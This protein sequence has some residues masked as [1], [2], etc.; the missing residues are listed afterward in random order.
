MNT[1]IGNALGFVRLARQAGL[2][3]AAA[4]VPKLPC[5]ASGS[6]TDR[7][8]ASG[9]TNRSR[10]AAAAT[11][12]AP[13]SARTA[14]NAASG[15]LPSEAGGGRGAAAGGPP[16]PRLADAAEADGMSTGGMVPLS[17]S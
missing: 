11:G 12:F 17:C 2:R 8:R 9:P 5:D 14:Q 4:G 6:G 16:P 15:T 3:V 7:S 13:T 1:E 10:G